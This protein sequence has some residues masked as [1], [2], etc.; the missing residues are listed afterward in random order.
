MVHIYQISLYFPTAFHVCSMRAGRSMEWVVSHPGRDQLR[1]PVQVLDHR[2]FWIFTVD[3]AC[4]GRVKLKVRKDPAHCGPGRPPGLGNR[5][6]RWSRQC[7]VGSGQVSLTLHRSTVKQ[8]SGSPSLPGLLSPFSLLDPSGSH[9]QL[10]PHPECYLCDSLH[11]YSHAY[12][13]G[14]YHR[15]ESVD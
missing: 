2:K 3:P 7:S 5:V 10:P 14:L 15:A 8:V 6:R 12:K 9:P 13:L 1:N 11:Q 4:M